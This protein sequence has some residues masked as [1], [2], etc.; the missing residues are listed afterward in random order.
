VTKKSL[1]EVNEME[2][3]WT[4]EFG[5]SVGI[6][7]GGVV[8]FREGK[9]MG[10]DNGYFYLG[11]YKLNG[12]TL[13]ATINV[14]PFIEGIESAFKTLGQKFTLEL[15]GTLVDEKRIIAQGHPKEMPQFSLGVKLTK[16]D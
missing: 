8:V 15:V 10:G 9:I 11:T 5:S 2:G 6:F 3:L 13:Q 1:F 14:E 7:G 12:N 16:R 4:A